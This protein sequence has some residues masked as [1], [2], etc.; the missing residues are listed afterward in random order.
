[1]LTLESEDKFIKEK[2]NLSDDTVCGSIRPL[3]NKN[4]ELK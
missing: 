3:E 1:M 2:V 4:N